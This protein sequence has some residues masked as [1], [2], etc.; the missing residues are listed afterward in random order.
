[1][2][3]L[4]SFFGLAFMGVV[5]PGAP[6]PLGP[7]IKSL[8]GVWRTESLECDGINI[9]SPT[10]SYPWTEWTYKVAHDRLIVQSRRGTILEGR[11][12]IDNRSSPK[13]ID[14]LFKKQTFRGIIAIDG[15]VAM[16]CF[17][18]DRTKPR[19]AVFNTWREKGAILY[20]LRKQQ[21]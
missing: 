16:V 13:H 3:S 17:Q 11:I 20:I 8:Q 19:P 4:V 9:C 15:N 1:M 18:A 10:Y 21:P 2:H 5:I 7:A 12:V 14:I 6:A